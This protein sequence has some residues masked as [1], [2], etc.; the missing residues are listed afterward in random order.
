[1]TGAYKLLVNVF[2]KQVVKSNLTTSRIAAA[3]ERFNRIRWVAPMCTPPNI[4]FL[5]PVYRIQP[6]VK[7][8]A[9]PV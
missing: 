4:A 2:G 7:A 9:Q 8:V 3:H 6:V 1:M 5:Y